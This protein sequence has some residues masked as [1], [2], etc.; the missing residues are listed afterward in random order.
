MFCNGVTWYTS[1]IYYTSEYMNRATGNIFAT[2]HSARFIEYSL[3]RVNKRFLAASN[4]RARNWRVLNSDIRH[5][6]KVCVNMYAFWVFYA[7]SSPMGR[8]NG[9]SRLGVRAKKWMLMVAWPRKRDSLM[10]VLWRHKTTKKY[11]NLV[12]F[13]NLY[14]YES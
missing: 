9:N 10:K 5:V 3:R 2:R 8:I 6:R 14:M 1:K 13:F 12:F 11:T 7:S 4:S